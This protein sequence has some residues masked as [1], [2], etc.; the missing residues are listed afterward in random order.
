MHI[1]IASNNIN[2]YCF[3]SIKDVLCLNR[4]KTSINCIGFSLCR[5]AF[6]LCS[7]MVVGLREQ[8]IATC[9]CCMYTVHAKIQLFEVLFHYQVLFVPLDELIVR[10]KDM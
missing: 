9:L 3:I 5:Q 1:R 2:M 7:A 8:A 10:D 4:L 6:K